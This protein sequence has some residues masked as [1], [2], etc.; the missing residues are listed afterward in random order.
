VQHSSIP[1]KTTRPLGISAKAEDGVF[2][3]KK[4]N[5]RNKR[6]QTIHLD[7]KVWVKNKTKE[8]REC[9]QYT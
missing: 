6:M 1:K 3:G 4:Q 7:N 5:Q 9:K 8:I 2:L